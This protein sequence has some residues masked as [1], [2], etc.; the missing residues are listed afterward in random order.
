M[1][2]AVVS[3]QKLWRAHVHFEFHGRSAWLN[4][5]G[6]QVVRALMVIQA[7][8]LAI[9]GLANLAGF[10][11]SE[12]PFIVANL[13]VEKWQHDLETVNVDMSSDLAGLHDDST[14]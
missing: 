6:V 8:R 5:L 7:T 10:A 12:L 11:R 9:G 14:P 4:I 3:A 2:E 1:S 13:L